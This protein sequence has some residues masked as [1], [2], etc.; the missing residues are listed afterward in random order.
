MFPLDPKI[1]EDLLRKWTMGNDAA[2]ALLLEIAQIA[3][4]AD[5]I[6]DEGP[7]NRQR[8]TAWLLIRALV[9]L[10]GNP[11]YAQYA[12][13]L[14]PVLTIAIIKWQ[15]SDEWRQSGAVMR[16]MFGFVYR[17]AV[18]DVVTAVALII[19]GYDHARQVADELFDISHTADSETL[20]QWI[21]E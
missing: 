4:L 17:E 9:H 12:G 8:N 16:P 1:T 13:V 14:S 5:D 19:G 6:V 18:R 10:P 15:Q 20:E 2:V 21:R 7:E 3:R 11:F